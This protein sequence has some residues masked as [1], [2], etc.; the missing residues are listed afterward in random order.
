MINYQK[1]CSSGEM[2]K[3]FMRSDPY[4]KKRESIEAID[5]LVQFNADNMKADEERDGGG[6]LIPSELPSEKEEMRK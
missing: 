3:S 4:K 6:T 2:V 5:Y 1:V